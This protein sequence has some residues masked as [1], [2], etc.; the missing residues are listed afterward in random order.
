MRPSDHHILGLALLVLATVVLGCDTMVQNEQEPPELIPSEAFSVQADLFNQR[1]SGHATIDPHF[2]AAVMRVWPVSTALEP[3]LRLPARLTRAALNQTPAVQGDEWVWAGTTP[4]YGEPIAFTL[5]ARPMGGEVDWT[6]TIAEPS[7]TSASDASDASAA[8]A[9]IT[10]GA[11]PAASADTSAGDSQAALDVPLSAT[12]SDSTAIDS[13]AHPAGTTAR[14]G[15]DASRPSGDAGGP[16]S[17]LGVADSSFVVYTAQT[18]A[19]GT[20]GRWRLFDVVDDERT[21]VLNGAYKIEKANKMQLTLTIPASAPEHG[22]D[23]IV[24]AQNDDQRRL[25]WAR[26]DEGQTHRVRWNVQSHEGS[27]TAS[28]YNKGQAA[29]WGAQLNN[30]ECEK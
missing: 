5:T 24:Y 22:G 18:S 28:N 27:I 30:V 9:A 23:S 12:A 19:A 7:M 3:R 11:A 26:A 8:S 13:I 29:C 14:A 21:N 10:D 16:T 1:R 17:L 4:M 15:G 25:H 20:Q 6:M 2:M